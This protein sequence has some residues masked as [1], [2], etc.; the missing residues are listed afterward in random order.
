MLCRVHQT[1]LLLLNRNLVLPSNHIATIFLVQVLVVHNM[2]WFATWYLNC[3]GSLK[4]WVGRS[5]ICH[6]LTS[7]VNQWH[8]I[9]NKRTCIIW[10]FVVLDI[11]IKLSISL[12]FWVTSTCHVICW[13]AILSSHT[14]SLCLQ[15]AMCTSF[16]VLL[17]L[18]ERYVLL[19]DDGLI[20][21]R[22]LIAWQ[23]VI[24][25]LL[26][27]VLSHGTSRF[28]SVLDGLKLL[29]WDSVYLLLCL[30]CGHIWGYS[31]LV[32]NSS[33]SLL[34]LKSV[35]VHSCVIYSPRLTNSSRL[36]GLSWILSLCLF[37]SSKWW[38]I[39]SQFWTVTLL[40]VLGAILIWASLLNPII[41][42]LLVYFVY[43][44][45]SRVMF[46]VIGTKI[47]LQ[48]IV[49]LH[50]AVSSILHISCWLSLWIL[51]TYSLIQLLWVLT[52][53]IWISI[54][55]LMTLSY[56]VYR[57]WNCWYLKITADVHVWILSEI[58]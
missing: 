53:N 5:L 13:L 6:A 22:I 33:L 32:L 51:S 56:L 45:H 48:V 58:V 9:G 38:H 30:N 36:L 19:C 29:R 37:L 31:F 47:C 3:M 50:L 42:H 28:T 7:F 54:N 52:W 2:L 12:I 17:I 18:S 46:W 16:G 24:H 10:T 49:S 20:R 35:I 41:K 14:S 8:V 15:V 26:M 43:I 23:K 55:F 1:F 40:L 4:D 11:I 34:N 25:V 57:L 39:F 21:P 27:L 44:T